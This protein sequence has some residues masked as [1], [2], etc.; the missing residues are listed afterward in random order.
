MPYYIV[1]GRVLFREEDNSILIARFDDHDK[2][3]DKFIEWRREGH[4]DDDDRPP[5]TDDDITIS[6]LLRCDTKPEI[7]E[8]YH[9]ERRRNYD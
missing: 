1:I 7:V 2:A 8:P 3:I 6:Y 5:I 4:D 9:T